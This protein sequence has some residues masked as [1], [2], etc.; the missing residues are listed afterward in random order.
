MMRRGGVGLVGAGSTS[1]FFW[2]RPKGRRLP[3]S[4]PSRLF[5]RGVS[6]WTTLPPAPVWSAGTPLV[7]LRPEPRPR[8][9][10]LRRSPKRR[11]SLWLLL[12]SENL[13]TV[14]QNHLDI[15]ANGQ[16]RLITVPV[17][18]DA[19]DDHVVAFDSHG[20]VGRCAVI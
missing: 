17:A 20:C 14:L 2:P 12:L 16:R 11:I 3:G 6:L 7:F 4:L 5:S 9:E 13:A 19:S 1:L 10:T 8:R 15:V 18:A